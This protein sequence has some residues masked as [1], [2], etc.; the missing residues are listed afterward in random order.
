MINLP[1]L[2]VMSAQVVA[3]LKKFES[4]YGDFD[5]S[6]T[7]YVSKSGND[8]NDGTTP[9]KAKLTIQAA[10]DVASVGEVVSIGPGY[11]D[12]NTH[13]EGLRIDKAIRLI[14]SGYDCLINNTNAG[15]TSIVHLVGDTGTDKMGAG[16]F[17]LIVE[18]N[19]DRDGGPWNEYGIVIDPDYRFTR[20]YDCAVVACDNDGIHVEATKGDRVLFVRRCVLSCPTHNIY[21]KLNEDPTRTDDELYVAFIEDCTF[22]L[23]GDFGNIGVNAGVYVQ[24]DPVNDW[25]TGFVVVKHNTFIL[26]MAEAAIHFD[27]HSQMCVATEN[28][29][30]YAF[31]EF[32]AGPFIKDE[33]T[34]GFLGGIPNMV[35]NNFG[36]Y[37]RDELS[38]ANT[39]GVSVSDGGSAWALGSWVE[40]FTT[41]SKHS[42]VQDVVFETIPAGEVYYMEVGIGPAGSEVMIG[43]CK[44]RYV[45]SYFPTDTINSRPI[46]PG[47]RVSVRIATRTGGRTTR[48]SLKL[49]T[50]E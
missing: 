32:G 22:F 30:G 27:T 9:E 1:D 15:A 13:V 42:V 2:N 17:N 8:A 28:S 41:T 10:V 45:S 29:F 26:N 14:G 33:N 35:V 4:E 37:E 19:Q 18:G 12:E 34:N 11:Y 7:W 48:L 6:K 40:M 20:I 49:R 39:D 43:S 31:R 16:I 21:I 38:H 44:A 23:C 36:L 47:T 3:R 24:G 46:P 50:M 25:K 5:T